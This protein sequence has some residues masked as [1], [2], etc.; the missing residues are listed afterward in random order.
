MK[1]SIKES[2]SR[3]IDIMH[4]LRNEC[5]WDRQQ[6]AET[7]RKYI[8][9]EAYETVDTIDR[10]DWKKLQDELGDLLLQIVF[11]S[12][13]AEE[14]GHFSILS[15]IENIND[16][17]ISRH[18]HVFGNK[19]VNGAEEV[20]H[21]WEQIKINNENR[22]SLLAGIPESAPALLR[23][24]RLQEK[25]SRVSFDWEKTSDVVKQLDE[26]I[27]ELKA[28]ITKNDQKNVEEEVGDLFFTLVNLARFLNV[29]AEDA[30]RQTNRKFISRFE[31]IEKAFGG[32]LSK[33]KEAGIEE[34]DKLWHEAKTKRNEDDKQ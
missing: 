16:K 24:Q 22:K 7:L 11:Q 10:K 13:I 27:E 21:N 18:P 6:T 32:D 15:V 28:A 33:M 30:L 25:A 29:S 12:E 31:Y 17:L 1:S 8:L 5:P 2:F 19:N 9:E 4:Q 14:N 26:D 34:L 20:E 23:S 3:L